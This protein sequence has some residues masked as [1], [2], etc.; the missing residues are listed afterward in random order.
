M[1]VCV[2][3]FMVRVT[4]KSSLANQK[5]KVHIFVLVLGLFCGRLLVVTCVAAE[6]QLL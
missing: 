6:A 4:I 2:L 3:G 1:E 5:F